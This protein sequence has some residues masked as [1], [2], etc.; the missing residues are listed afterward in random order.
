MKTKTKTLKVSVKKGTNLAI[1][2][3]ILQAQHCRYIYQKPT[4]LPVRTIGL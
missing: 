2:D 3:M 1:R 4:T